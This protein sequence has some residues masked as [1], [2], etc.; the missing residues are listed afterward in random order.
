MPP[1]DCIH[2]LK[3]IEKKKIFQGYFQSLVPVGLCVLVSPDLGTLIPPYSYP[4]LLGTPLLHSSVLLL[5]VPL[6]TP[7]PH[8][9]GALYPHTPDLSILILYTPPLHSSV[10]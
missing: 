8:T 6:G 2:N 1:L 5:L 7:Y 4:S 10:L 3:Q 9:S